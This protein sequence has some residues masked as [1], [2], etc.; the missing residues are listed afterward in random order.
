MTE[1]TS[2][3]DRSS[4]RLTATVQVIAAVA[5]RM[6]TGVGML[7][8]GSA[9]AALFV[10][11]F[12]W[13]PPSTRLVSL[14]GAG[15]T[16]VGLLLP[17]G[18][19]GLCYQG[20]HD[21]LELPERVSDRTARTVNK[22]AQAVRTVA[23]QE[24]SGVRAR[25]WGLLKRIWTLRAILSENR[26]LLLHYGAMLRFVTPGFLLVVAV[27]AVAAVL[28]IFLAC[29]AGLVAVLSSGIFGWS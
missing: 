13:W 1:T 3:P 19:L 7:A 12:V 8:L 5:R 14:L 29:G 17:A 18:I 16:L 23:N 4:G 11:A 21:L 6:K 15:V 24:P 28:I 25:L 2:S 27:A 9:G 20:L 10:W 22:S 26:A